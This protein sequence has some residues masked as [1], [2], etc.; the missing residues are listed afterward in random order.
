MTSKNVWCFFS[1]PEASL[2]HSLSA[3]QEAACDLTQVKAAQEESQTSE[4]EARPSLN[5]QRVFRGDERRQ[6][7]ASDAQR[8]APPSP[9]DESRPWSKSQGP[10]VPQEM[11]IP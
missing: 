1:A 11:K 4:G 3:P 7:P 8:A 5:S 2:H 6:A 9:A 10:G